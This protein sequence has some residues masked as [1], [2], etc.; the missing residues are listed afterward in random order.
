MKK[1][2]NPKNIVSMMMFVLSWLLV[3]SFTSL[4]LA[5]TLVLQPDG[6]KGKESFICDCQPNT[7]NPGGQQYTIYHGRWQEC[8][9][10]SFIEWDLSELPDDAVISSAV[11]ELECC[12]VSGTESGQIVFYRLVGDWNENFV[13]CYNRPGYTRKGEIVSDWPEKNTWFKVDLTEFMQ[14]W[15]ANPDSNFGVFGDAK[16]VLSTFYIG[17]YTSEAPE[18]H[19]PKITIEYTSESTHV[20][21]DNKIKVTDFALRAYPNPFNPSTMIQYQVVNTAD[22]SVKVY[23]TSGHEVA[24]LISGYHSEGE[25]SIK[26]N[27][28]HLSAGIYFVRLNSGQEMVTT[29]VLLVK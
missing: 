15:Q 1:S 22:I 19:R 16:D 14:F 7:T 29:K 26:F 24:E 3:F 23:N 12:Y 5:K 18:S 20:R 2:V 28:D 6:D 10:Q 9:A 8:Y 4:L 11:M 13:N 25:H 27:A 17:Y 21:S